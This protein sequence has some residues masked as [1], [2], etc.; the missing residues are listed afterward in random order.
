MAENNSNRTVM[1]LAGSVVVLLI[2]FVAVVMMSLNGGAAPA[3]QTAGNGSVVATST[4]RPGMSSSTQGTFDPGTAT[5]VTDKYTPKTFVAAYYQAI[6]DKK[7]DAAF[8]MQPAASISGDVAGFQ[9]TWESYGITAYSVFS[10]V[11]SSTDA[12]VVVRLDLGTNGIWN[13]TWNFVKTDGDWV[14]KAR[15]KIGM[16]EPTK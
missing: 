15:S 10:D 1:V 13:T 12:T 11:S 16:G 6:L 9:A 7:W 8:K 3:N 5:K 2:V 4:D 14:V